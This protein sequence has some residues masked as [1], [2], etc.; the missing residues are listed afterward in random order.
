MRD[1][2]RGT[3]LLP[4]D[5]GFEDARR[6]WNRAVEQPVAAVV[7]AADADDVAALVRHA[8]AAGLG[9]ATQPNGHGATGRTEGTILLRT[10]R[11]DTLEID[12][13]AARARV[14]AGVASG[15]LQAA[16]APHGLTGL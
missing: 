7:E 8:A 14:G 1:I 5:P 2:I 9:V 11:L 6:P 13:A 10:R 12:P 15:A 16:A 4:G 3:V